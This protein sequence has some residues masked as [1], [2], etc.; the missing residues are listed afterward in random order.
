MKIL[1]ITFLILITITLAAFAEIP[2]QT[3]QMIVVKNKTWDS[4]SSEIILYQRDNLDAKWQIF[5]KPIISVVGKKGL[6]WG[7]GIFKKEDISGGIIR[8]EGDKR[9]PAGIFTI[10]NSFGVF[11][12]NYAK[13]QIDLKMPYIHLTDSVQ[14]IGDSS[15]AYYNMLLDTKTVTPDWLD[16]SNNELMLLDGIRDEA[17][18]KWGLFIDNN[19]DKNPEPEMKRQKFAGS[20]IFMHIWKG[21]D[22][23]TSGCVATDEENLKKIIQWL[24]HTKN[25]VIVILPESEYVRLKN[26]WNL[27]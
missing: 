20:C 7:R 23:G 15:S 16:E 9:A 25:P 22:K 13:K 27:P 24:D 10:S 12:V 2:V 6:G 4:V 8:Q 26:K 11:P 1:K 5:G 3:L 14:C 17:A 21:P 18:Y 19:S